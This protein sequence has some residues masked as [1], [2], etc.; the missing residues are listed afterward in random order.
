MC[1][2]MLV[3]SVNKVDPKRGEGE[4]QAVADPKKRII[5]TPSLSDLKMARTKL[6]GRGNGN[7]YFEN[8]VS[9]SFIVLCVC[10]KLDDISQG[11]PTLFI[12]K[13]ICG[14]NWD[15]RLTLRREKEM[16]EKDGKKKE[17]KR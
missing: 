2:E 17:E 14:A 10:L 16:G 1:K 6:G 7:I 4:A 13:V 9:S 11:S 15:F 5:A 3:I 8:F 12:Q